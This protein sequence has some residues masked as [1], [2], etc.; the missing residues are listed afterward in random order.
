MSIKIYR[1]KYFWGFD[2]NYS[3]FYVELLFRI[4]FRINKIFKNVQII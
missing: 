4:I 1:F 3:Q 2:D